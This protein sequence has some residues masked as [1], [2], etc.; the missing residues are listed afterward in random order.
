MTDAFLDAE[1]LSRAI[2]DG[3]EAAFE[4]YWRE[5]DVAT[6]P[7]HFDAIR[8]GE[9]GFNEPFMRELIDH[10]SREP[11]LIERFMKV[12]DRSVEPAQL[13][14]TPRMLRIVGA[15][16]LRGR[17]D[18]LR[19]FLQVGRRLGSEH[20]VQAE[21]KRALERA[22]LELERHAP[23]PTAARARRAA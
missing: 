22:E 21:C 17:L 20:K 18:V 19:G 7:L 8:Q 13:L 16:L 4:R 11:A 3:R 12:I 10:V 5:R 23:P 14:S 1:R 15:S 2:L 6:L 9:V